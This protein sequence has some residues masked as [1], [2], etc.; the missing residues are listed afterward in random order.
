MVNTP[1]IMKH[2]PLKYGQQK[3]TIDVVGLKD[4][5]MDGRKNEWVGGWME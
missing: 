1:E 2:I 4:R 5:L 3:G